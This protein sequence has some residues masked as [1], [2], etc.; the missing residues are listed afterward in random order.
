MA[1]KAAESA[2]NATLKAASYTVESSQAIY[3]SA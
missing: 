1:S 3:Q 2:K